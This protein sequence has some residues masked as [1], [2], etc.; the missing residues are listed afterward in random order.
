M[1]KEIFYQFYK[2]T[3]LSYRKDIQNRFCKK[4]LE[5]NII[6][7][8][9]PC[10]PLENGILYVPVKQDSNIT[11]SQ[12]SEQLRY[13]Y[14]FEE[15]EYTKLY[16]YSIPLMY[17]CKTETD[18]INSIIDS[19]CKSEIIYEFCSNESFE[20]VYEI[21]TDISQVV[22]YFTKKDNNYYIKFVIQQSYI[23]D[24]FDVDVVDYRYPIIICINTT[25][26]LIDIR[27]DGLKYSVDG[28]PTIDFFKKICKDIIS[29]IIDTLN[30][31]VFE[32]SNNSMYEAI[33]SDK[34]GK[35]KICRQM[36]TLAT[37]GSADLTAADNEDNPTLPF[38]DEIRELI[39]ENALL[40][41]NS[42]EI[43][44]LLTKYI[45][46]K[47]ATA[48][49]PYIYIKCL[50]DIAS[51]NFLV[52]ITSSYIDGKMTLQFLSGSTNKM[53]MERMDYVIGFLKK[54]NAITCG[55]E[56]N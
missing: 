47:E 12:V 16:K 31:T 20:P 13:A 51:R 18:T 30:I 45:D 50:N 44:E 34:S 46:D 49:Y 10:F 19:L 55:E 22:P 2:N 54:I 24:Q 15:L 7:N 9:E 53:G 26:E 36:M 3:V 37:G 38:V 23:K 43:K 8:K 28:Q 17:K 5:R 4:M 40:F 35:V 25:D 27:F 39:N 56:I 32:C 1:E 29:W 52:K 6:T 14:I 48:D 11:I 41:D 33:K 42:P 21:A